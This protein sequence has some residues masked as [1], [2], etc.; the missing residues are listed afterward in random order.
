M[1]AALPGRRRRTGGRLLAVAVLVLSGLLLPDAAAGTVLPPPAAPRVPG[2]APPLETPFAVADGVVRRTLAYGPAGLAQTVDVFGPLD[3]TQPR[4]AV[5]FVHG[6][7]WEIGDSTEWAAR[8]IELVRSRGWVAVSV[9]YRLTPTAAW[10][11]QLD[12]AAAALRLLQV[13]ADEFG[14]DAARIGAVGDSAGAQLA[15]LLGEPGP[16]RPPLRAV[17]S[18][19]GVNDLPGLLKQKS[20]GGCT[21]AS[22]RYSGAARRVASQLLACLPTTCPQDYAAASPAT[23]VS[24]DH[25]ATL[26][27][28]SEDEQIDPR[29][30][31]VMDAALS[32]ASVL[33]R[34]VVLPGRR[35]ARG[36]ETLVWP[37]TLAFF[38]Q[39]LTPEDSGRP[40]PP[41]VRVG[42]SASTDSI[43]AGS[44]V[45]LSGDVRPGQLGST[46]SLQVRGADGS[47]RS[48]R[49]VVL[50]HGYDSSRFTL[51][52][53]AVGSGPV[54]WRALWRGGGGLGV[55]PART[56]LVR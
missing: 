7:G 53:P 12:D 21:S 11:A 17:V 6:G 25:A 16:D 49:T 55:S 41:V 3:R 35:H 46:V 9:N 43:T 31:W 37:A 51:T 20:S 1:R 14:I 18:W 15:G 48:A 40:P 45:T 42:L 2:V 38:A 47:W 27:F 28:S 33:S 29:Q 26:A 24:S 52:W 30:A 56:V 36:F 34:V 23:H 22:C 54:L 4:P 39:T 10:P 5:L 44:R 32:R 19:S 50:Q 8:A 13:R